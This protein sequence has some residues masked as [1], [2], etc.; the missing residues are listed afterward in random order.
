M[1]RPKR[2][3]TRIFGINRSGTAAAL[4]LTAALL[5]IIAAA[6]A[7][8]AQ[9]LT[10]VHNFTGVLPDGA[11]PYAGLTIDPAGNLYGTT[12]SGGAGYGMVFQLKH[13]NS[14]F[15]FRPLYSFAG[16]NDGALPE[17]RVTIGPDGS[18]YG[19]TV[20]GGGPPPEGV[21]TVYNLK[22]P[23][24]ACKTALCPWRETVLFSFN[25]ADGSHPF[26]GVTF[27]QAGNLYG[28]ANSGGQH[29]K[30]AVYELTPFNGGWTEST[31]YTFSGSDGE[32][33]LAGVI[34]D[35]LGNLYGT[36]Q[37]GGAGGY[38]TVFQ[39]VPA[40]GGWTENV[41][42]Q[43][44]NG[45]DGLFPAAGL[46]FDPSGNLYGATAYGGT[47]S[48][49]TV[50]E[51][52]PSNGT[53]TYSLLY[54]FTGS[55]ACG[56]QGSLVMD[57]AGNLYGTTFCDGAHGLGSVFEL[58]PSSGGWTYTALYDFAGARNGGY[59]YG[60]VVFDSNGNLYGTASFGGTG[61][62]CNGGS[63]DGCGIVWEITP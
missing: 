51:L 48:G 55:S 42:Y 45:P 5:L 19:T 38:G 58:S 22:P 53:W 18:L 28:T 32:A 27:D 57:G 52:T 24:A 30:G 36:T 33:P 10:V 37:T 25:Q 2:N 61:S 39:L 21:G 49:G 47:G 9:T 26:G 23:P 46:I 44:Q 14:G 1:T 43:F 20:I 56:P 15:L 11:N 6:P 3:Q 54:S 8:Q 4:A 59:P 40:D 41:L 13:V 35:N 34:F 16:G 50:F 17:A 63:L 60:S 62:D 7:A 12:R 31:A 29:D